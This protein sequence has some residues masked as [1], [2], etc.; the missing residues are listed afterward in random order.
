M[1]RLKDYSLGKQ[2]PKRQFEV[3]QSLGEDDE[4]TVVLEEKGSLSGPVTSA[5]ENGSSD[6]P[7]EVHVQFLDF[8]SDYRH[9]NQ[10]YY[11]VSI[12]QTED[13]EWEKAVLTY[14]WTDTGRVRRETID[15]VARVWHSYTALHQ[16][17]SLSREEAAIV[18]MKETGL[19]KQE[20][21]EQWGC[22]EK[23]INGVLMDVRRKFERAERTIDRLESSSIDLDGRTFPS[24]D[25]NVDVEKP[26][27]KDRENDDQ[28]ANTGQ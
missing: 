16:P 15:E 12:T 10:D 24:L 13:G 2:S 26:Q 18:S 21:A 11:T 5:G 4:I 23:T 6:N 25:L 22:D 3:L 9:D 19:S 7:E 8:E 27:S 14:S 28:Q 20:I 17:T 1:D